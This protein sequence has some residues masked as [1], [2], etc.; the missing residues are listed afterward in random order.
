MNLGCRLDLSYVNYRPPTNSQRPSSMGAGGSRP[1]PGSNLR[2][3]IPP[4]QPNGA[5]TP[6]PPYSPRRSST[7]T[8]SN[9]TPVVGTFYRSRFGS[10]Q[11]LTESSPNTSPVIPARPG[12]SVRSGGDQL[13][14]Y[15]QTRDPTETRI[16]PASRR[17]RD[18]APEYIRTE[19][20][21]PDG[22]RPPMYTQRPGPTETLIEPP[23]RPAPEYTEGTMGRNWLVTNG[24][25]GRRGDGVRNKVAPS[26]S[27][28]RK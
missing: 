17:G 27:E 3:V 4:P 13:P 19:G 2:L 18:S 8:S 6:P 26:R 12:E 11:S 5:P 23:S 15:S 10:Q 22:H 1:N 16:V 20:D 7:G 24:R 28:S 9:T 21:G 25:P 14:V